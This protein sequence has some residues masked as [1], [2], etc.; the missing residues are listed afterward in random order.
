MFQRAVVRGRG[1]GSCNEHKP[2]ACSQFVLV[3]AHNFPQTAPD[4]IARHRLSKATRSDKP[5]ARW[6]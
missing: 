1:F 4:A 3:P 5:C 2:K 6:A